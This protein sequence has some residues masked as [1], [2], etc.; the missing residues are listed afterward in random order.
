MLLPANFLYYRGTIYKKYNMISRTQVV[1]VSAIVSGLTLA[2]LINFNYFQA[3]AATMPPGGL[4]EADIFS[5]KPAIDP[6][7]YYVPG[8]GGPAVSTADYYFIDGLYWFR[9][10]DLTKSECGAVGQQIADSRGRYAWITSPDH[11]DP[12][13]GWSDARH[14]LIGYSDDIGVPPTTMTKLMD[15]ENYMT[16]AS[17]TRRYNLY[18]AP[19]LVC[20]PE[21]PEYPFY[22][23]AEGASYSGN[24]AL[25]H[26]MGLARFKDLTIGTVDLFGP[27][28]H[29]TAYAGWSSFQK[30]VRVGPGD[31]YS[32]GLSGPFSFF[33]NAKY[34]ST[35]GLNWSA[36]GPVISNTSP[37][38]CT[39]TSACITFEHGS[40]DPVTYG[41]QRYIVTRY[42]E[43]NVGGGM[44]VA[45]VPIDNNY[46]LVSTTPVIKLSPRYDGVYPGPTYLQNVSAVVED[47]VL[48][49]WAAHGFP[50][51]T[52]LMPA[53]Y[54]APYAQGGALWEQF[55]DYYSYIVDPE[56]AA[57]AAPVG[58]KVSTVGGVV[59]LNWYDALPSN[60]YRVY[61]ST[62]ATGPWSAVTDVSGITAT[63][64]PTAGQGY[65]YKIVTL[66]NGTERGSRTVNTYVSSASALVNNHVTRALADGADPATI[67][68]N[69]LSTVDDFLTAN[70]LHKYLL[71][72]VDAGFGVK[73]TDT[74]ITKIYD[75]GTTRLPR[76]GD[77]TT[78]AAGN[79]TYGATALNNR[80]PGWVNN[81]AAS[82]GYFGGGKANNI[83]RKIEVTVMAMYQKPS[84]GVA[85]LLGNNEFRGMSLQHLAGSPGSISFNLTDDAGFGL[86]LISITAT[87]SISAATTTHIIAGAFD[88][89]HV[90]VYADGVMGAQKTGLPANTTLASSTIL[91]GKLG[92]IAV[93]FLGSGS[94]N[95]KFQKNSSGIWQYLFNDQ[96]A[97]FTGGDLIVFEKGLDASTISALTNLLR[98]RAGLLVGPADT[99][100]P[101][102]PLDL[103]AAAISSSQINLAWSA[104]TDNVGVAGYQVWRNGV[105]VAS[106]SSSSYSD[107]A[108]AASTTYTYTVKAFDAAGNVSPA[109]V[110]VSATTLAPVL[111]TTA[112]S[113]PTNL[114]GSA[115]SASQINLTWSAA[116]DNVGVVAYKV[117]RNGTQVATTTSTAYTNTGLVASSTYTYAVAAVDAAG[118]SSDLSGG[119][120]VTTLGGDTIPPTVAITSPTAGAIISGI[121]TVT[122]SASDNVGVTKVEYFINNALAATITSA[123]YS[124][125]GDSH[126]LA[127]GNYNLSAK[128]YDAAGNVTTSPSVPITISN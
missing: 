57:A 41:G 19:W 122:I 118:N 31:W 126:G 30:I 22:L 53:F 63:D 116:T 35:D 95:T 47:G 49:V 105:Y 9:P 81:T 115:A 39:P 114:T 76:G 52:G 18:H 26:E 103:T 109:S 51:Y 36:P 119:V 50:A 84:T 79:T 68:L 120:N 12:N 20:N 75:L 92:N 100:A 65:W 54:G 94:K 97:Q 89:T 5:P 102:T 113:T 37:A 91:K 4:R 40:A 55:I 88:G 127:N 85:S 101:S 62:S 104:A 48:H 128:A 28:H 106:P 86:P 10:Y 2:L 58:V 25:Q 87:S 44:Y 11:P 13:L 108:L 124:V 42:D 7:Q 23:Y 98:A 107:T 71:H 17:T 78:T 82:W 45:M 111:D 16:P 72:W 66:Q 46:N 110:A 83:R 14:F 112:P 125:T 70:N 29:N 6:S 123:P 33:G 99:V 69:W 74:K 64:Q 27:T 77:Y 80:A 24:P 3:Q 90:S 59:T 32:T 56:A 67:D 38:G 60:T 96:Q 73:K 121:T 8:N 61:R 34:T 1:Y 15:T 43:R 117:F 93:P 21:D